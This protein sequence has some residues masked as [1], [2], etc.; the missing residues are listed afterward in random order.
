[1]VATRLLSVIL[2][3][4]SPTDTATFALVLVVLGAAALLAC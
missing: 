1:V 4:I 2:Y 3:G